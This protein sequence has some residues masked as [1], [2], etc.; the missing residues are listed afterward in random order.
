MLEQVVSHTNDRPALHGT[1]VMP[2]GLLPSDFERPGDSNLEGMPTE[3]KDH[4]IISFSRA[5]RE[6]RHSFFLQLRPWVPEGITCLGTAEMAGTG[7]TDGGAKAKTDRDV[8]GG[9]IHPQTSQIN[10]EGL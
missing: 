8:K 9:V 5:R 2:S 6:N 3:D 7:D 4:L 1:S 10:W